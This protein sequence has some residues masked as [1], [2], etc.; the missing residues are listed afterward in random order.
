MDLMQ[1]T[2][3]GCDL[4]V[5]YVPIKRAIL[6]GNGNTRMQGGDGK[7]GMEML[8]RGGGCPDVPVTF[9]EMPCNIVVVPPS[10]PAG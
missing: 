5:R 9:L 2:R 7:R 3:W 1:R 10:E 4:C 8:V 6:R